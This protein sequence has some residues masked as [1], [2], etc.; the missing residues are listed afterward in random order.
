VL[1]L[2]GQKEFYLIKLLGTK[3]EGVA[4]FINQI[5]PT[6]M[7]N[8][9]RLDST[10]GNS[11]YYGIYTLFFVF[12][13]IML[14]TKMNNWKWNKSQNYSAFVMVLVSAFVILSER[15]LLL[16]ANSIQATNLSTAESLSK[17]SQFIWYIGVAMLIYFGISFVRKLVAREIGSVPFVIFAALNVVFLIFTQQRG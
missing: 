17:V 5:Y 8:A 16:I 10:L 12:I 2:F 13:S 1:Q 11:E 4:T 7:G 6:S 15:F 14:A 3:G 9:L